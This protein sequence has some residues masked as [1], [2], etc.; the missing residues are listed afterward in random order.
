MDKFLRE[1]RIYLGE[2]GVHLGNGHSFATRKTGA[3]V[4]PKLSC[5]RVGQLPRC[6]EKRVPAI[7]AGRGGGVVILQGPFMTCDLRARTDYANRACNVTCNVML[8][9]KLV[10]R[11][12]DEP[13][14]QRTASILRSLIDRTPF[15]RHRDECLCCKKSNSAHNICLS[16][17][18]TR[19]INNST[20]FRFTAVILLTTS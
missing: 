4:W 1:R 20:S 19:R 8:V 7:R 14:A 2:M 12:A 6:N 9:A 17:I 16:L 10:P 5:R 18:H 11:T 15:H 13:S 3:R